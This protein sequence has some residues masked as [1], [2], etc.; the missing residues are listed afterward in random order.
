MHQIIRLES[1]CMNVDLLELSAAVILFVMD[2]CLQRYINRQEVM[3][4]KINKYK[5]KYVLAG[6]L[7]LLLIY[8][9]AYKEYW[10]FI[11]CLFLLRIIDKLI[12]IIKNNR[13]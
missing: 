1:E 13:V 3:F 11:C 4:F 5:L 12:Y 6:I 7:L 10:L 9:I 8:S 2:L